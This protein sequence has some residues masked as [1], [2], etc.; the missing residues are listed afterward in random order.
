MYQIRH[1]SFQYALA[2]KAALKDISVDIEEGTLTVLTGP[3]GSGKSTLLRHLKKEL[4]PRGKRKGSILY[5]GEKI[6]NLEPKRSAAETGYLFQNP[7]RQMVMDTVWHE[8]AFGMENLGTSYGQMKRTAAEIVNYCDLQR[9]YRMPVHDLSGGE[10][11]IV[12]LA[13]LMAVHPRVLILDE[14]VAQ[15]DPV[16]KRDFLSMVEML[17]KEFQMTIVMAAHDLEGILEKAD[18]CI[19]MKDGQIKAAG[20]PAEMAETLWEHDR[21]MGELMPQTIRLS[22]RIGQKPDFSMGSLRDS[23]HDRTPSPGRDRGKEN[24]KG[25]R[26]VCRIWKK[27]DFKRFFTGSAGKGI[28]GGAGSQWKRKDDAVE[29]PFWADERFRKD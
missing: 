5:C 21:E 12:N 16:G 3:S 17:R 8:I 22:E 23:I 10:K 11:Q 6:E 28:P 20:T 1:L 9:I 24:L 13:S 26:V 29:V 4:L 27:R 2:E 18:Q 14:P 19:F 25:Q 15:L 7:S